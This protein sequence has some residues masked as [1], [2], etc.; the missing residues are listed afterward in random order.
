MDLKFLTKGKEIL[1][2]SLMSIASSVATMSINSNLID[3]L[4]SSVIYMGKVK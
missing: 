3:N 4:K 2:S 1:I